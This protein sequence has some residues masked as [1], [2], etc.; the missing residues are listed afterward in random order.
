MI[1][2]QTIVGVA[3]EVFRH[4]IDG[5]MMGIATGIAAKF[6][7]GPPNNKISTFQTG[8]F[9]EGKLVNKCGAFG[10]FSE[11]KSVKNFEFKKEATAK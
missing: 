2:S 7:I 3:D 4:S 9:H 1:F 6:L 11:M 5:I 10:F 8:S